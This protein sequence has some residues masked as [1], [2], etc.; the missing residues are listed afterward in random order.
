ME[1]T[2]VIKVKYGE[3]L[4]RFS[5][6]VDENEHLDLDMGGLRGKVLGLFNFSPD[7]D[8]TLTYVD[9]DG[10]IV[11]LVDEEDLH[12]AVRQS[13]NPLRITVRLNTERVGRSYARSSGSSTPRRSPQ[14]QH[15]L[16]K[17]NTGVTDILKSVPEPFLEVLSKLSADLA[18]K[19]AS[20]APGLA[21]LV[22][23]AGQTYHNPVSNS[24]A[25]AESSTPSGVY[26]NT[27]SSSALKD[28]RATSDTLPKLKVEEPAPKNNQDVEVGNVNGV[29][30]ASVKPVSGSVDR[31]S[32]G[33]ASVGLMPNAPKIPL[34]DFK[35]K[36]KST[37]CNFGWKSVGVG[38]SNEGITL[39]SD[40]AA[41]NA[42][43]APRVYPFKRS[44][45]R[46]DGM[47]GVFHRGVRCDGC[48]VHP[49]TGP[50]F[51]SKQ[52]ED[53]DLCSICFSVVGN[54]VD[55]IRMDRPVSYRPPWSFKG[56]LYYPQP[57]VRPPTL[58][59]ALRGCAMKPNRPKLDS[60]F[61]RDVNVLDGT[62]MAPS[63]PFTKIWRMRNNGTIMW[64]QGTQL[65][66][67]GGD[68]LSEAL[69]VEAEISPAGLSANKE[70]DIAV[71]FTAP[72]LPGRYISYWRMKA[73]SGQKFGQRVW[74][75]IQVDATLKDSVYDSFQGLNL[76]LPPSSNGLAGPGIENA[77]ID[78]MVDDSIL[79]PENN[80]ADVSV[81]PLGDEHPN[82]NPEPHLPVD[83]TSPLG[84]GVS[85]PVPLESSSVSY[86]IIDLS[87]VAPTAPPQA[88]SPVTNLP[89]SAQGVSGSDDVEQTL[90][91]ELA[92]MG[93]RQVDLNKEILR[94]NEYDL[95]QSVDVLCGVSEWDPMLEELTEM[96]FSDK[97]VNKRLLK[98]NNG[99]IK[100]AVMDL[101]AG[102]RKE[103]A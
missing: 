67:I 90:L 18:S 27:M 83:G 41:T 61:I 20:S 80:M 59:H 76:N 51:K 74:V 21:E 42:Q 56:G 38:A 54:E 102:E 96:G 37:E 34:G 95:E 14:V 55:Y 4:R 40:S 39:A 6:R 62:V 25:A 86:P 17:L 68:R 65:V 60:R 63:T 53:Y 44:N 15:L 13:L 19:A 97:E 24:P 57:Y 48:G 30:G 66:W 87:D 35:E 88:L 89:T 73:P 46:S 31:R 47:G 92:E 16:P 32:V 69:S 93:F 5:A 58:P 71:D 70:L 99:S 23:K 81:Q 43:F 26:G 7:A 52:K 28:D 11:A 100:H 45:N 2:I 1:S 72:E 10:D 12:D 64:P 78:P 84:D 98:K 82:K 101:I 79:E 8:L 36:E 94:M 103:E 50:R 9:E 85:N 91:R 75:L 22:S 77:G 3:T 49:I 33:S 29:V